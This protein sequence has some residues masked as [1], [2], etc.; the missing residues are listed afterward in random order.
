MHPVA[1]RV[2]RTIRRHRLIPDA[3]RVVAAVSGGSDSV[4][5]AHV[6]SEL[7]GS[8]T[9]TLAGL[10]HL[11]HQLRPGAADDDEAFC[12]DL[13]ARLSVPFV[14]ETCDVGERAR[15]EGTSVE[16]AGHR[17]RYT[18][19]E[20]TLVQVSAARLALGH[21]SD[22]QAETFLL[23]LIRG[24]GPRGLSSMHPRA[25][26]V[27]RPLLETT[28]E[29]LR[30]YLSEIG[31]AYRDDETNLDVSVP[32][33]R[34]RHELLPFLIER[35]NPAIVKALSREAAIARED[36]RYLDDRA[37]EAEMDIVEVDD[38]TVSIDLE[39]LD[40]LPMA[41]ASRL[42]QRALTRLSGTRGAGFDHIDE[43]LAL[44]HGEG[45]EARL[46]LPGV[47]VERRGLRIVLTRRSPT[48]TGP[49]GSTGFRYD[50][51]VP[52]DVRLAETGCAITAEIVSG[53]FGSPEHLTSRGDTAVIESTG[54]RGGLAVRSRKPGDAFQP[55]GLHGRK[56][57]QDFFVDRKV[58]RD[59]RDRVPLV[60]NQDDQIVWVAGHA[61]EEK[62][63]VTDRTQAVIIL[64]IRYVGG[65]A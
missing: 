29:E 63:R 41:L 20:R 38:D 33:N 10:A 58:A 54:L 43:A 35:F 18:F 46:D 31:V 52:G 9:F 53:P 2:L 15:Q 57:L 65:L 21:T 48:K 61:I 4:A 3:G 37:A 19:Y 64:K 40:E 1:A 16:D 60:V 44:A 32:R 8:G 27:I 17:A 13:A 14:A 30:A 50:L 49:A 39:A 26:V 47:K 56:K 42:V 11:N 7:T 36:S 51:P 6:L 22:D 5:L 59:E 28:R 23:R 62:F 55:L 12:R 45:A 34:I 25:G 24:A